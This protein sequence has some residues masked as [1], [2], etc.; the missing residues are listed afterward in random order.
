VTTL[1]VAA[2]AVLACATAILIYELHGMPRLRRRCIV[3]LRPAF[4]GD[5]PDAL[6]GVLWTR[7]G[8]WL[9]LKDARLLR[10]GR[11]PLPADGEVLVDRSQVNFLQVQ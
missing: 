7:R 8:R 2:C 3:N 9:V 11:A 6:E 1:L 10:E 5:E 4:Q